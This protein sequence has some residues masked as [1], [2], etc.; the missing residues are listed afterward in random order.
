MTPILEP[1]AILATAIYGVLLARQQ[2][3]DF[4]GVFSIALIVSFGGGTLRDLLIDRNPIFWIGQ[5]H[6]SVMVFAIALVTSLIKRMPARVENW[7]P[8]PDA[9][10]LGL[11]SILG[12][13]FALEAGTSWFVASL[14]GVVTGTF[15]GVIG[16]VVCNRIPSLFRPATRLYASCSFAGCWVFLLMQW[17]GIAESVAQWTGIGVIVTL[18]LLSL[19]FDWR[20]PS[21]ELAEK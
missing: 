19:K 1:L 3:M 5:W 15:G 7:L 20:L 9:L 16:D 14:L 10:G 21:H 11:Y 4:V 6:Y 8:I 12:T 2:R 13:S 17:G 18:R